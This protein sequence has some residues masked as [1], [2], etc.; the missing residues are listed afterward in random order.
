M[1]MSQKRVSHL[2]TD[3]HC[4]SECLDEALHHSCYLSQSDRCLKGKLYSEKKG[5]K[6]PEKY[7]SRNPNKNIDRELKMGEKWGSSNRDDGGQEKMK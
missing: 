7:Q 6:N 4:L 2:W 5:E 3:G 1:P